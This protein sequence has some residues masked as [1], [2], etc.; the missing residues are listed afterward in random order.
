MNE[1]IFLSYINNFRGFAMLMIVAVHSIYIIENNS[2]NL[3]EYLDLLVSNSSVYLVFISGFLFQ[4]LL[5]DFN[6]RD[7][8]IRKFKFIILPYILMTFPAICLLIMGSDFLPKSWIATDMFLQKPVYRQVVLYYITG[9][10]LPHFWY[11]PMIS[12]IFIISPLLY[13]VDKHPGLYYALPLLLLIAFYTG[14]PPSNDNTLQSFVFFLPVY[15]LG[16]NFSHYFVDLIKIII[17]FWWAIL[18][19]IVLLIH[20]S[21]FIPNINYL[22]KIGIA[23]LV[24]MIFYKYQ[25]EA[26]DRIF[27][28][29]A[30]YSF[31]IFF[32][33]KYIMILLVYIAGKLSITF[34]FTS[35][36]PGYSLFY[37]F[38]M[39]VSIALLMTAKLIL[40]EN[41]R[42]ITGS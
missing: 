31:G 16:M 37:V 12:I 6:Y 33:H 42:L 22:A 8:L 21:Q 32:I 35:G 26:I 15:I 40:K 18:F 27:G 19:A 9:A 11:I 34:L 38:I 36:I 7:Y 10:H 3:Y 24:I 39:A 29:V 5:K 14:R 2:P 4:Y 1:K 17:R 23:Y 30:K 25:N 28:P 20:Y 41:S 13:Y